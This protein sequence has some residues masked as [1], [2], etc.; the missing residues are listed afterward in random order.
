M[1]SIGFTGTRHSLTSAQQEQVR[2]ILTTPVDW[3]IPRI[4]RPIFHHGACKGAD[5]F[6]AIEAY[7]LYYDVIAH[8]GKSARGGENEWLCPLA[9][10]HSTEV[11]PEKTHFARNR[12]IVNEC[13]VLIAC[14][15]YSEPI[16]YDTPGGTAYTVCYARKVGK[17]VWIIRPDGFIE[18]ARLSSVKS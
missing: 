18:G 6:A 12:D 4:E 3:V 9:I 2:R 10:E 8:P 15:Q 14:P 13:D 11:R 17:P 1:T 16:T 5:S 7:S